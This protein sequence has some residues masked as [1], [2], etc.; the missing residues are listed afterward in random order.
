MHKT[1]TPS[2]LVHILHFETLS[3]LLFSFTIT[4]IMTNPSSATAGN[5]IPAAIIIVL[6][7]A[8]N[9]DSSSLAGKKTLTNDNN[10]NKVFSPFNRPPTSGA[11][12]DR[13]YGVEMRLVPSGPNPLH[14]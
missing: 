11:E 4:N 5:W 13:K 9:T 1:K 10:V 2:L 7:A 6:V 8:A 14:N 12:I 3:I